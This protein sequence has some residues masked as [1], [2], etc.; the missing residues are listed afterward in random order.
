MCR[1][2]SL[3]LSLCVC[4][5]ET[6]DETQPAASGHVDE[7]CERG[8][9]R[10]EKC[11]DV[12]FKPVFH[13]PAVF[14]RERRL[15][16]APGCHGC[17]HTSWAHSNKVVGVVDNWPGRTRTRPELNVFKAGCWKQIAYRVRESC[18]VYLAKWCDRSD[19]SSD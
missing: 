10:K 3:S 1:S 2:A 8:K 13:S 4:V 5:V 7:R 16:A 6:S 9:R 17:T 12:K 18:L 15:A 11:R 14:R 19:L